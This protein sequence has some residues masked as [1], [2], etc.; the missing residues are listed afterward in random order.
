MALV[1]L[2]ISVAPRMTFDS[3]PL[4]TKNPNTEAMRT[5]RDLIDNPLTD[6]YTIDIVAPDVAAA[7]VA[8]PAGFKE[9][10]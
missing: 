7:D 4:H 6:P 2:A 5:L 3:N 8:V 1:G 10:K 9:N